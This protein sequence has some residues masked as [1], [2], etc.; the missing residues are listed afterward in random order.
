MAGENPRS[1]L[2][3]RS[4]LGRSVTLFEMREVT[5]WAWLKQT[6]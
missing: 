3:A 4:R 1:Q 2:D 6:T 5:D